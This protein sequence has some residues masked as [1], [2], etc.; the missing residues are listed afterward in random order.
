MPKIASND[1][2]VR[3]EVT[4]TIFSLLKHDDKNLLEFKSDVIKQ[5]GRAIQ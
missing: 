4:Q 5:L 1:A 3:K 2:I